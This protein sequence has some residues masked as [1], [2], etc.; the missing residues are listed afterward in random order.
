MENQEPRHS[1]SDNETDFE[2]FSEKSTMKK[3]WILLTFI[4]VSISGLV[5]GLSVHFARSSSPKPSYTTPEPIVTTTVI[6]TLSTKVSTTTK[7]EETKAV[8]LLKTYKSDQ[9]AMV[10]RSNGKSDYFY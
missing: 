6:N 2:E 10:I 7:F 1:I 4:L 3:R 9:T 5:V 8:L